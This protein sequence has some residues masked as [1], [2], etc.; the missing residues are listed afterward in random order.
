MAETHPFIRL[1]HLTYIG[2]NVPTVGIDFNDDLT[3]LL[4][5]SN[6][7]KSYTVA[8]LNFM[9]GG[10]TPDTPTEGDDYESA[11]LG[12]SFDDGTGVTLRRALRGGDIEVFDGLAPD[13][14]LDGRS[15][16]VL[17]AAHGKGGK[18]KD[19]SISEFLLAKLG[20][21]NVK[22]ASTQ[23]AKLD[24]FSMR[25]FMPYVLIDEDR[26]LSGKTPTE[27]HSKS[28]DPLN[29]NTFRFLLT[30]KDDSAMA[31]VPDK[32]TLDAGKSG[33]LQLLDEMISDL[34]GQLGSHDM[35]EVIEQRD[36]LQSHLENIGE[37]LSHVQEQ[38]DERSQLRRDALDT[39]ANVDAHVAHLLAM[40]QRFLDL[41]RT[42]ETDIRRLEAIEEGGFLFQRFENAPCPMCGA[43]P[44]HQHKPHPLSDVDR[45]IT[46]TRAEITKIRRDM[47]ELDVTLAS[48]LAEIEGLEGRSK[49]LGA[50]AQ[51]HFEEIKRLR[52]AEAN[53][54][55][56]YKGDISRLE[57]IEQIIAVAVRRDELATRKTAIA[58]IKYGQQKAEGLTIGIDG[59]TGHRFAQ[60][61]QKVLTAW[62]YPGLEAVTWNDGKYDIAINGKLRGRNG[63]GV[64]ALLRTAFSVAFV[65]YCKDEEL[66]HPG[67]LVLDSPLLTYR[68]EIDN[69]PLTE[70]EKVI[71]ATPLDIRFYEHLASIS[72][73]CQI[74]VVEN[75]TPPANLRG[76]TIVFA[77]PDR[78]GLFPV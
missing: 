74:Y 78:R 68:E 40:Q 58:S 50:E 33:K 25:F 63:K 60:V 2:S 9:F 51:S 42:Y 23:A 75:K 55:N 34:D 17:A 16:R 76:Q 35:P 12:M 13:G 77:K 44:G 1:E 38:L 65:I 37:E 18:K 5:G 7:G 29:K 3:I 24:T 54:R 71:K 31:K 73:F 64:K 22:I 28:T 11:L 6:T 69:D 43:L 53:M 67:F 19:G 30:G 26:M 56:G 32:K 27:I 8:T 4:G 36:R 59:P 45:Q 48:V 21:G 62:E 39:Q 10:E 70:E 15:G 61:V 66:P 49:N 52:P 20:I 72:S 41:K 46:A 14:D 47:S 57:E